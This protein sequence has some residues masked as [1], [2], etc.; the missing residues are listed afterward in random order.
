MFVMKTLRLLIILTLLI[1][2]TKKNDDPIIVTSLDQIAGTWK[3][4]SACGG[5]AGTCSYP[6]SLHYGEIQ[7]ATNARYIETHNDTIYL[8]AHYEIIKSNNNSGTLVLYKIESDAI[9]SQSPIC[10]LDNK[11]VITYGEFDLT[12]KKTK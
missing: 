2:C 10:I 4:E 1:S 11:L 3:W 12:Y 7:F 5:F 8:A 9:L 6:T